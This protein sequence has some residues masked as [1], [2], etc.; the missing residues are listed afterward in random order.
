MN[1][2]IKEELVEKMIRDLGSNFKK[3]DDVLR[4][5]F[6]LYSPIASDKSNR[7]I[8]DKKLIP[9]IYN[10]VKQSYIRRGNEV[11]SSNSEGSITNTYIDIEEKLAKDVR[12]IRIVRWS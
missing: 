6:D 10:A 2:E 12:T 8:N 9:Y 3:D 4:D 11:S 7:R 5:Y 1:D